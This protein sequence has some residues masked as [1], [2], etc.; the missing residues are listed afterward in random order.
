MHISWCVGRVPI[1]RGIPSVAV[2]L[3]H[4][5]NNN[6]CLIVDKIL[7]T[8]ARAIVNTEGDGV[9]V[10]SWGSASCCGRHIPRPLWDFVEDEQRWNTDWVPTTS[11]SYERLYI[12]RPVVDQSPYGDNMYNYLT[13][14]TGPPWASF[15]AHARWDLLNDVEIPCDF[16]FVTKFQWTV[17]HKGSGTSTDSV[18]VWH[19]HIGPR[20]AEGRWSGW[21][22]VQ[23][24]EGGSS[25]TAGAF[26]HFHSGHSIITTNRQLLNS[27]MLLSL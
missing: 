11:S 21:G 18:L 26:T 13:D 12:G 19:I 10:W 8:Y 15:G 1:P 7:M 24:R 3:G 27:T 17:F 23:R 20:H 25:C 16:S 6:H 14:D 22:V 5:F 4:M 2:Q 9:P